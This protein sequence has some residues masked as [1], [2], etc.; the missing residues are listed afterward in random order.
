MVDLIKVEPDRKKWDHSNDFAIVVTCACCGSSSVARDATAR[1]SPQDQKWE[2]S[3]TFDNG[4]CDICQSTS[5]ED[6]PL[7]HWTGD[8][9]VKEQIPSGH[10]V[11]AK[12]LADG[13]YL[14]VAHRK[15]GTVAMMVE[16]F[17]TNPNVPLSSAEDAK[18]A[19][20]QWL[21]EEGEL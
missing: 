19:A 7:D 11:A 13:N 21:N 16:A 4:D 5:L 8:V 18:D 17:S 10:W 2:M 1:W 15:D 20:R 9:C 14:G 12:A 6:T 3:D